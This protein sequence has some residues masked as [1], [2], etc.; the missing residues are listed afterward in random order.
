MPPGKPLCSL[1]KACQDDF[2]SAL[3]SGYWT[4]RGRK[5]SVNVTEVFLLAE[6]STRCWEVHQILHYL[7]HFQAY[8]QEDRTVY[9]SSYS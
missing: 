4:F 1:N 3:L 6:P 8:N 9:S 5:N 2:R 7:R